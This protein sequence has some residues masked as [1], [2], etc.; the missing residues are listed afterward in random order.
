[1]H[2]L[3]CEMRPEGAVTVRSITFTEGGWTRRAEL[4]VGLNER[5]PSSL[6]D[7]VRRV[8][9]PSR[10]C[11]VLGEPPAGEPDVRPSTSMPWA[12]LS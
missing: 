7:I 4:E 8:R 9:F 1:M 5:W 2:S 11:E 10:F 3:T 12:A 6:M